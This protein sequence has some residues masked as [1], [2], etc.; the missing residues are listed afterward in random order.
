MDRS[1]S[2]LE[3][4]HTDLIQCVKFNDYGNKLASCGADHCIRVWE[5][6]TGGKWVQTAEWKA[7]G[8]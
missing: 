1:F 4:N 7:H 2:V 8:A 5:L 3:T 6:G